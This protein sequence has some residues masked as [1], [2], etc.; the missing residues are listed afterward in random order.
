MG[1][2]AVP[3]PDLH[4]LHD[5]KLYYCHPGRFAVLYITVCCFSENKDSPTPADPGCADAH[6]IIL[7]AEFIKFFRTDQRPYRRIRYTDRDFSE[8]L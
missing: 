5:Q 1:L 7:F 6:Y 4:G 3:I 2:G 8:K